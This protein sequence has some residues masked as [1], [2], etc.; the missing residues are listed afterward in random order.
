MSHPATA[1]IPKDPEQPV[2]AETLRT[3][4]LSGMQKRDATD[5]MRM[6]FRSECFLEDLDEDAY[7]CAMH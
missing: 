3:E 5:V 7:S 1:T 6:L 2:G 4:A